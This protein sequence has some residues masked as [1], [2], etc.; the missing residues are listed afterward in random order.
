MPRERKY[1][2]AG[3]AWLERQPHGQSTRCARR[4]C[5]IHGAMRGQHLPDVLP[6]VPWFPP[7]KIG[8]CCCWIIRPGT[9]AIVTQDAWVGIRR[10]GV[11]KPQPR[12]KG[13]CTKH[14]RGRIR[15]IDGRSGVPTHTIDILPLEDQGHRELSSVRVLDVQDKQR[16]RQGRVLILV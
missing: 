16:E 12:T 15:F 9:Q 13:C 6:V 14:W 3:G 8:I 1:R 2:R 11:P 5:V 4:L 7:R 10:R